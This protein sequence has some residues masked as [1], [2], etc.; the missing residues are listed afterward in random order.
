AVITTPGQ[1]AWFSFSGTAGQRIAYKIAGTFIK[2]GAL[3]VT[4]PSDQ[5]L[6]SSIAFG[7]GGGWGDPVTLPSTGTY[8]IHAQANGVNTGNIVVSLFIVPADVTSSV[9]PGGP[10]HTPPPT[11]P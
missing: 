9:N 10:A 3:E 7:T 5:P 6:G 4:D 11:T 2:S 1:D 8:K